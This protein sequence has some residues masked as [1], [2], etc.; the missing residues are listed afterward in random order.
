MLY[1]NWPEPDIR[2]LPLSLTFPAWGLITIF[3]LVAI[4]A[5]FFRQTNLPSQEVSA[6]DSKKSGP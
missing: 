1:W 4:R 2:A 5:M 6:G 3:G